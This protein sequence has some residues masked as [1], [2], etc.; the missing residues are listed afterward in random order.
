MLE[1]QAV[2]LSRLGHGLHFVTQKLRR[3][4]YK[5]GCILVAAQT[6]LEHGLHT[7]PR[8]CLEYH[9]SVPIASWTLRAHRVQKLPR[10][11]WKLGCLL[12]MIKTHP[13]HG[14]HAVP[15]NCP[16]MLENQAPSLPWL[17]CVLNMACTP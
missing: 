13:E 7:L 14:L 2:S 8:N 6:S 10:N 1:N 15:K 5:L 9:E 3:N 4:A 11:A 12:A 17:G 16:E